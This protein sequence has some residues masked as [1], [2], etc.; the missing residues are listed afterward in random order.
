MIMVYQA[1]KRGS[2]G[3][4]LRYNGVNLTPLSHQTAGIPFPIGFRGPALSLWAWL[5]FFP[6]SLAPKWLC[7]AVAV[8]AS[9][10]P[11]PSLVALPSPIV[12]AVSWSPVHGC[13]NMIDHLLIST[14]ERHDTTFFPLSIASKAVVWKRRRCCLS[15]S[16][17]VS[18]LSSKFYR[19]SSSLIH[20]RA[21]CSYSEN[22]LS[23]QWLVA[24][25]VNR[26]QPYALWSDRSHSCA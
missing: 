22:Y 11:P 19:C 7:W 3:L 21:T 1:H 4:D 8:V 25:T 13:D 17:A 15:S 6:L 9:A 26:Q 24:E 10:H 2:S 12:G 14:F 23:L 16:T 5:T 18:G 20:I